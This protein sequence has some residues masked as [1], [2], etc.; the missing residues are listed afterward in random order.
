MTSLMTSVAMVDAVDAP[1][2]RALLGVYV[3]D[4]WA[5]AAATADRLRHLVRTNPVPPW[6]DELRALRESVDDDVVVLTALRDVVGGRAGTV[7]R[8]VA[9]WGDRI[10]RLRA[11]GRLVRLSPLQRVL[12]VEDVLVR[13][14]RIAAC[15]RTLARLDDPRLADFDVAALAARAEQ[16]IR[17]ARRLHG[18]A[19]DAALAGRR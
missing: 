15:W 5:A 16:R 17:A 8:H 9:V 6:V 12:D 10:D 4:H 18:D 11:N 13:L 1:A 19:V 7:R 3:D 2:D 14:G